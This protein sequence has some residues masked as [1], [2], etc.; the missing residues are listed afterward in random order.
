[1]YAESESTVWRDEQ[2]IFSKFKSSNTK[3]ISIL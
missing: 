2:S 3:D 1:M